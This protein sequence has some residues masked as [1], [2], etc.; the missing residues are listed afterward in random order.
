MQKGG[1][2]VRRLLIVLG[3]LLCGA[4]SQASRAATPEQACKRMTENLAA[5]AQLEYWSMTTNDGWDRRLLAGDLMQKADLVV[6]G[7]YNTAEKFLDQK[8]P[9]FWA[10]SEAE[11]L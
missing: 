3:C 11:V 9:G 10:W 2:P 6:S 7:A 1:I 8:W 4:V 5:S